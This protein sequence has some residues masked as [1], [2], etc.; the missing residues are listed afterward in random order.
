M[1]EPLTSSAWLTSLA[2]D[3]AVARLAA[4]LKAGKRAVATGAAG[5]STTVIAGALARRLA[6][7]VLLVVAHNDEAEDTHDELISLSFAS[8]LFPALEI[9]PGE[10]VVSFDLFAQR[11]AVQ[12][13][14]L[15]LAHASDAAPVLVMPITALMQ[16]VPK[17]DRLDTLIRTITRGTCKGGLEALTR[18]LSEAGYSRVDV[19]EEPG[20]YA[21]RGGILDIF[22]PWCAAGE[23]GNNHTATSQSQILGVP[24]RLDFFGDEIESINEIDLATMGSDRRVESVELLASTLDA[25]RSDEGTCNLLELVPRT[26][27]ALLAETLE[28]VEQARGYYER[29]TDTQGLFGPP[30]VLKMLETRFHALAEINQFSAGATR[31]DSRIELPAAH[32]PPFARDITQALDELTELARTHRT[33]VTCQQQ[34]EQ[35]RL[36]QLINDHAM[37]HGQRDG[38]DDTP[39]STP[40]IESALCHVHTGFLWKPHD[41][42]SGSLTDE[43]RPTPLAIVPYHEL[44]GK[45][46]VRS[47]RSTSRKLRSSRAMDTFLDLHVG[48]YV[49][50]VDHG[51]AR[52]AGL[53]TMKRPTLP[54]QLTRPNAEPEEYLILEFAKKSRFYVPATTIDHVQK[55]IGGFSGKPPLST[56][57]S[58]KW[59]AQKDRVAEG[60]RDL[61]AEMLRVRAARESIPGTRYPP[62]TPWQTA[63]EAEFP[64]EETPDQLAAMSEIKKDLTSPRPMDR[65]V[66]GD[67]GFGK[68][69]LAI[70]AA[71]KVCQEGKQVAVL[72]PTTVLAEQHE[73]TFASRFADYPFRIASLSRFKNQKEINATLASLRRGEI[74]VVI[75][76]H[77]LL[78]KDVRFADLGLV[79]ID[80]EQRFGVEHKE[81]LLQ[82]RMTVDVLTLSAT[83]IPRTLHM[84]MMGLRDIS[85]LT[86]APVDRR[87]IV[88]EVIP[89]NEHRIAMAIHRELARNGQV[90]FVHNRVHNIKS[91]ADDLARLVPEAR[92]VIGHGQMPAGELEKIM[93]TFMR[94]QADILVC[95][96]IIESGIDIPTANTM[97]INDA[98]RFG[99]AD[100]H[101]LR[102]RVGRSNHRAYCYLLLPTNRNI[103]KVAQKRLKAIEQYAMLGAGFKIAMRDL[104][105]RG[106]GNLLGAEQSGHIAAVGYDMY[107]QLLER[108]VHLLKHDKP[109]VQPSA[110]SI[111]IGYTG[112]IP[113]LYIPSDQRRLEAYRRIATAGSLEQLEQVEADMQAAYGSIPAQ[114]QRLFELAQLRIAASKLG[115]KTITVRS[116]DV[117]FRCEDPDPVVRSLQ[118]AKGSVT[119]LAPKTNDSMHEVYYRPPENY[120]APQTLCRVLRKRLGAMAT[121]NPISSVARMHGADPSP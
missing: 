114:T 62:D 101:Q 72:V 83:P 49:V 95:T 29:A 76:T 121:R 53:T 77:R 84:S 96:T 57:G 55:Y 19:I 33:I 80:E 66:C 63:F 110:T 61:A 12:R 116:Q 26:S 45:L 111:E 64:Y 73:R 105:I 54:G 48:D 120:L 14:I 35:T 16:S 90:Y 78:S 50:H 9:L 59:K 34:A 65:L 102:G 1:N 51:I 89:Y 100:L 3:Q 108:A 107:C 103:T 104:E 11:I 28:V 93:L 91:V 109:P 118:K 31:S 46:D 42:T 69:E 39:S 60:V 7:P 88:T 22:P 24:V 32:L 75:G 56:I 23:A 21:L 40:D 94:R 71:F 99:L 37:V 87:A 85:S 119:S 17:P 117:V 106:A 67:V 44:L 92:I 43:P 79:V 38:P 18:W 13:Q 98:D 4:A 82:L 97:I 74:D 68:T 52:F 112:V 58:K 6:R 25:V 5:S 27:V 86:T 41:E 10:T 81:R 8:H 15:A 47:K 30:A 70:R 2:S 36:H 115:V 113:K 20:D